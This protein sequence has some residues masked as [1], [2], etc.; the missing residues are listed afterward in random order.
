MTQAETLH[1]LAEAGG[2]FNI[3]KDH[4]SAANKDNAYGQKD[5][6]P[7]DKVENDISDPYQNKDYPRQFNPRHHLTSRALR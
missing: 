6:R 1:W 4:N 3:A 2:I 5:M 7:T